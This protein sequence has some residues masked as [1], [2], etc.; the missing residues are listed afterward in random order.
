M[1]ARRL[2]ESLL[3]LLLQL[4]EEQQEQ[5]RLDEG[6]TCPAGSVGCL[7]VRRRSTG[8]VC[9]LVSAAAAACHV[10]LPVLPCPAWLLLLL[11]CLLGRQL[12][13]RGGG[14]GGNKAWRE[15]RGGS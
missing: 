2:K 8:S 7:T 9:W 5:Q 13:G 4:G 1:V 11:L 6:A 10:A 15:E 14:E 12:T 3:H